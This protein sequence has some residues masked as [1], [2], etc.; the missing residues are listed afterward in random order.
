MGSSEDRNSDSAFNSG[1]SDLT[2]QSKAWYKWSGSNLFAML[3]AQAGKELKI[4]PLYIFISV[5]LISISTA[6]NFT[7]INS[8]VSSHLTWYACQ[9]LHRSGKSD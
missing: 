5:E 2:Y 1:I 9:I 7:T 4:W 8:E 3:S 6:Q